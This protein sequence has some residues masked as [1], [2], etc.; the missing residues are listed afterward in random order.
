VEDAV[1]LGWKL[2][3]VLRGQAPPQLLDSYGPERQP[4]AERNTAYA[5]LGQLLQEL[6]PAPLGS[7]SNDT[8]FIE[9]EGNR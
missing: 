8:Q 2:A 5:R 7:R 4:L 9:E 6:G 1:N 3:A